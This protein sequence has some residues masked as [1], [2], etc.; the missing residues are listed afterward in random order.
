[1]SLPGQLGLPKLPTT[2]AFEWG[3]YKERLPYSLP[4]GGIPLNAAPPRLAALS[5][6]TVLP[7]D[8][9]RW[10]AA[11]VLMLVVAGLLHL[12]GSRAAIGEKLGASKTAT[13]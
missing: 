7:L 4:E 6:T 3:S 10:V 1:L 8:A 13:S 12:L 9:L 11:G 5:T 2:D